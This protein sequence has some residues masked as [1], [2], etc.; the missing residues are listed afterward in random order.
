MS[1]RSR[2]YTVNDFV[3]WQQN[4]TLE[5]SPSFQRRPVWSPS[6]K[7]LLLD[8]VVRDLPLPII[9]IREK[10]ADL[11]TLKAVRTV[12]D[13][14]QRIRTLLS[15]V[16]PSLL[17]DYDEARDAFVVRPSHNKALANKRFDEL[18]DDMQH[19]ILGYQFNVYS[20]PSSTA[21]QELLKIF[22]RLNS[23]GVKLNYQELRNAEF[24]GEFKTAMYSLAAEQLER[25]RKLKVFTE[26]DIARMLEVELTSELVLLMYSNVSAKGKASLDGLYKKYDDTFPECPVV[27]D[28]F[29]WTMD[30]L[31]DVTGETF[32]KLSGKQRTLFYGAFAAVYD[33]HYGLGS[34]LAPKGHREMPHRW[35][36]D[37]I[38]RLHKIEDGKAPQ[39]AMDATTHST[40]HKAERL[41]LVRYLTTGEAGSPKA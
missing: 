7:S 25:W 2:L 23:T 13:G 35:A 18:D 1:E 5:L 32:A 26:N 14:Q 4:G 38:G 27:T 19:R 31:A 6:A 24:E 30:A 29:Q 11:R 8:T 16:R 21:D 39:L 40:T 41:V 15:F 22:A 10:T 28:R 9:F 33:L 37:L 36:A 12:V 20:F 34:E 17:P 3:E